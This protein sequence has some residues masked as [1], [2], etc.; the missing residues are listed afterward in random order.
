MTKQSTNSKKR[1]VPLH[2]F[3][4]YTCTQYVILF[5]YL[6]W[7]LWYSVICETF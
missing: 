5:N 2:K 4:D 6:Q 1:C 7:A 3:W